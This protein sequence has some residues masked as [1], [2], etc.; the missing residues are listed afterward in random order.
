M[1]HVNT[2]TEFGD[3]KRGAEVN[4]GSN[5]LARSEEG[6]AGDGDYAVER[7]EKVYR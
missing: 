1:S 2:E 7:V 4:T 5:D 6:L 3:G